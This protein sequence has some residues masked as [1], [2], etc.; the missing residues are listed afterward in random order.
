[1]D[2]YTKLDWGPSAIL[3][4]VG[5]GLRYDGWGSAVVRVAARGVDGNGGVRRVDVLFKTCGPHGPLDFLHVGQPDVPSGL[6][7]LDGGYDEGNDV[8]ED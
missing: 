4:I 3:G 5:L 2:R 7:S 1:M 8:S 6:T